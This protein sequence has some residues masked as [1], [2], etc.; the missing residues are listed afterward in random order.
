M[1]K[2]Y[3]FLGL[4]LLDQF[5]KQVEMWNTQL[6]SWGLEKEEVKFGARIWNWSYGGYL[7]CAQY[8]LTLTQN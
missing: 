6:K 7:F 8:D 5:R 1:K 4:S 3:L 2:S